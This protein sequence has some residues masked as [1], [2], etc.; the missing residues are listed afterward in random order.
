VLSG[1][2]SSSV[3]EART[4]FF[5]ALAAY[6]TWGLTPL[7][8]KALVG[9]GAI[10]ILAHRIVWSALLLLIVIVC[11]GRVERLQ[12]LFRQPGLIATLTITA[13]L[14]GSNW[15]VYIIAVQHGEILQAS[16]G[17]FINPLVSVLLGRFL[18]GERLGMVQWISIALAASGVLCLSTGVGRIPWISLFLAISFALYGYFRKRTPVGP[19][20]GLAAETA[21]L[22]VPAVIYLAYLVFL[23]KAAFPS[24]SVSLNVLFPLAGVVTSV[25]LLMFAAAARRLRLVTI[26]LMQYIAPTISLLLALFYY[27]EPF[28]RI[29]L[30]S[31]ILIW[32]GLAL[33]TVDAIRSHARRKVTVNECIQETA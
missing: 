30:T 21:V 25:P 26:G 18:L 27:H 5:Y 31:F 23:G 6:T 19:L 1:I 11:T 10:E 20:E 9:I 7:Y 28:G 33:L 12:R 8:F 13:L 14:I 15:P 16:L 24:H 2:S 22:L 32:S 3:S 4:G 17:Y 29:Q